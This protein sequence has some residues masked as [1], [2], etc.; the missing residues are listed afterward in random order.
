[1]AEI[2]QSIG[3]VLD[4]DLIKELTSVPFNRVR[5]KIQL[6]DQ[7]EAAF[8]GSIYGEAKLCR[9]CLKDREFA[10]LKLTK[11]LKEYEQNKI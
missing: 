6:L 9:T 4:L 3:P 5:N 1:M 10:Y 11:Y 7:F 8:K 2:N